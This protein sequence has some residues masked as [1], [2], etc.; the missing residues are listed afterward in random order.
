MT[1]SLQN[2]TITPNNPDSTPPVITDTTCHQS[3]STQLNLL[4]IYQG[5][6]TP[7]PTNTSTSESPTTTNDE[8]TIPANTSSP[9]ITVDLLNTLIERIRT[10]TP[11]N[12]P[13]P[14][15]PPPAKKSVTN[16]IR[17]ETAASN[18]LSLKFDGQPNIFP[19][20]IR[21]FRL[22]VQLTHWNSAINVSFQCPS[23]TTKTYDFTLDF[24]LI[25]K[26]II[27]KQATDRWTN[28]NQISNLS[29]KGAP[30]FNIKLLCLFLTNSISDRYHT[31][32]QNRAGDLL[33][34]VL[35]CL[36]C[37]DIHF[38]SFSYEQSIKDQIW[39]NTI[40]AD[41]ANDLQAY[42]TGT[43]NLCRLISKTDD[44][45]THNDLLDPI[46][47]QLQ[48]T[49]YD[50]FTFAIDGWYEEYLEQIVQL[51][52]LKL[53]D[54]ADKKLQILRA[55]PGSSPQHQTRN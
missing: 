17:L 18:G 30:K 11:P 26:A 53:L 16:L 38:S 34:T 2:E 42:V 52:P 8:Q 7:S 46:F 32:L 28:A 22:S 40:A 47:T 27:V 44:N 5:D 21:K 41:I 37:T 50:R 10:S 43:T 3:N 48:S 4:N 12:V 39:T 31:V 51:T 6:S 14:P 49:A 13:L 55:Q 19:S 45:T 15:P 24:A 54:K 29:R 35:L 23:G 9:T 36:L 33:A 25:P 1:D 20:W